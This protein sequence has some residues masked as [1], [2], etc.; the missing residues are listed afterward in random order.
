M[1]NK[2]MCETNREALRWCRFRIANIQFNNWKRLKRN[3]QGI[4]DGITCAVFLGRLYQIDKTLIKTI[5]KWI[6]KMNEEK[7]QDMKEQE[8]IRKKIKS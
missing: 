2:K 4:P 7:E 3:E 5:N 1:I 6:K 8:K